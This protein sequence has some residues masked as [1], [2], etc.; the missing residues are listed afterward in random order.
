M[1]QAR[2]SVDNREA[3]PPFLPQGFAQAHQHFFLGNLDV[4]LL[5]QTLFHTKEFIPID[6]WLDA[7]LASD[8]KIA[9]I[10]GSL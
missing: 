2:R 1:G 10:P 9:W 5:L 3:Q 6:D 7:A 8:P 4:R